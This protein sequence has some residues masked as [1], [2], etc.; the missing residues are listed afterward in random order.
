MNNKNIILFTRS[1]NV[2]YEFSQSKF[3]QKNI[4]IFTKSYR[5]ISSTRLFF[6]KSNNLFVMQ[7]KFIKIIKS[8]LIL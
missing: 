6:L 3:H 1:V 2:E 8:E 4:I 5:K 7:S